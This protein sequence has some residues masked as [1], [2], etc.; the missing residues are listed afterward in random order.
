MKS[1]RDHQFGGPDVLKL[2][3][4]ADPKPGPGEVVVRVR[5]AGVNPVDAYIHTGTYGRKPP[6]PYTPG[7]DGAG[8]VESVGADVNTVL[9]PTTAADEIRVDTAAGN[10]QYCGEFGLFSVPAP[11]F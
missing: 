4:V 8:E 2:D 11:P 3:E 7:F 6:L 1:I 9:R 10:G 5:A